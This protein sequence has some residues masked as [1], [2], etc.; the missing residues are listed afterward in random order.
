MNLLSLDYAMIVIIVLVVGAGGYL[1]LKEI[2]ND[3]KS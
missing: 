1:I 2:I 3:S